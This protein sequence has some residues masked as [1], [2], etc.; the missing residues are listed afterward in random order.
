LVNDVKINSFNL[1]SNDPSGGI[2]LVLETTL[3]NPSQVGVD[4]QGLGFESYY[5]SVDIGPVAGTNVNLPPQ[6]TVT[7]QM[8]GRLIP[9]S[10]SDG[11]NALQT[12]FD[13]YLSSKETALSVKGSY[14]NGPSGQVSWLSKAFQQLTIQNVMLPGG[15]NNLT[16]IPAVTIKQFTFDFTKGAYTPESSSNDIEAQ[17]KNPFGFP[18]AITGLQETI[19]AAAGGHD[20]ATLAPPFSPA[21][22]DTS[23]G[24]IK[25]G[26]EHVPFAVH[27]N[28]D[29]LF[30][31][32][33][34]GLTLGPSG[35]IGLKG[36]ISKAAAS[37]AAGDFDLSGIG[38]DVQSTLT[39]MYSLQLLEE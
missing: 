19:T 8:N 4:L 18:L 5:G 31:Q 39:G 37:T 27:S 10:S 36:N 30:N 26:F 2:S 9:Q 24:I 22:T 12:M 15:P 1:P 7:V 33:V 16:L 20:M 28:A 14:A 13:N 29:E 21:T 17:F 35:T 6:G 3:T 34:K 32:F 23:T 11:L 25:T 38:Y